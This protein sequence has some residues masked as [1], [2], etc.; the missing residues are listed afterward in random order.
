MRLLLDQHVP[1]LL[2]HELPGHEVV[3][4]WYAKLADV[5]NGT[6]LTRA[7][8]LGFDVLI[9]TD[10][11]IEYE[12][13]QATLPMSVVVL[14]VPS[15]AIESIRPLLPKLIDLLPTLRPRTLIKIESA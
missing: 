14:R 1:H 2:R 9:T 10:K 7:A 15:N 5:T 13:N 4:A 8:T 12:Q 11:G 6:L 3:T